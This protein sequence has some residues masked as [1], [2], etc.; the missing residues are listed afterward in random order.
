M[1]TIQPAL[2]WRG[3]QGRSIAPRRSAR[4]DIALILMGTFFYTQ[5]VAFANL[6]LGGRVPPSA[7]S[8]GAL[9][10]TALGASLET[11]RIPIFLLVMAVVI[12]RNLAKKKESA[13]PLV[14]FLVF[15][16]LLQ[17]STFIATAS[18][19][20]TPRWWVLP[21]LGATIWMVAPRVDDLVVLGW[22]TL[23]VAVF[24][25]G[26]ALVDP[27]RAFMMLNEYLEQT[28]KAI[29]GNQQL[30]GP[31]AQM[32]LLGMSMAVGFPFVFLIRNRLIRWTAAAIVFYT[33]LWSASRTSV[34]ALLITIAFC[35]IIFAFRSAVTRRRMLGLAILAMAIVVIVLPLRTDDPH[36]FTNRGDI[37]IHAIARWIESPLVGFGTSAFSP[38]TSIA[39]GIGYASWHGHNLFVNAFTM[40]GAVLTIMFV[41]VMAAAWRSASRV[42][43]QSLVPAVYLV[44][45]VSL[46]MTEVA[47]RVDDFDGVSWIAWPALIMVLCA[48]PRPSVILE[49]PDIAPATA[50]QI[51]PAPRVRARSGRHSAAA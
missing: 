46:G 29:I 37:W 33:L 12:I 36:A 44:L 2:V 26:F 38:G 3:D 6:M 23:A 40:G 47:L 20:T 11:A 18:L 5:A 13:A 35:V 34:F 25:I 19:E 43:R 31:F 21:V 28:N 32:N 4:F 27:A 24:S 50:A 15:C 16:A 10:K 48:T 41:V 9:V 51:A 30:A 17:L 45:I 8:S 7:E 1:A 14:A 49:A 22:A 39:K 42:A